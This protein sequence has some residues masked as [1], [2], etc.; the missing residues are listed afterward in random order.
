MKAGIGSSK[1]RARK[2][3]LEKEAGEEEFE[4]RKDAIIFRR[5]LRLPGRQADSDGSGVF[6]VD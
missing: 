4:K 6:V 3:E 1:R 5:S 2:E